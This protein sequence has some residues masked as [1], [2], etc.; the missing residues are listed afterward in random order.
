MEKL[1]VRKVIVEVLVELGRDNPSVFAPYLN[2]PRWYL[3]RNVV[4]VL[5]LLDT[6]VALEMILGLI[7]HKEPRI[8]REVLSCL[9]RSGD[10][11]A[12]S[13]LIR[14]LRDES[15]GLRIKALQALG[16][17]KLRSALKPV[18]A[19]AKSDDFEQ[20]EFAEK[21]AVYE[22]LGELGGEELLPM[23]QEMLLKRYWFQKASEKEAAQLVTAALARVAGG[24]AVALLEEA[25]AQK[26]SVEVRAV[27]EQ[28]HA[29]LVAAKGR[30][31]A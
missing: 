23:F 9:E 15:S 29:T 26:R 2:D 30:K 21:K 18:L 27:L 28:A 31:G 5:S 11:K 1:K 12:K 22:T 3:V 16:R 17:E 10:P 24:K 25:L 7:S 20:K 19:M 6:P 4:L 13:Y 14:F 8:R